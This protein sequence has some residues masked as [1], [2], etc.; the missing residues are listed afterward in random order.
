[1]SMLQG[2]HRACTRRTHKRI[3]ID[4]TS[5]T[6]QKVGPKQI[7]AE[8]AIKIVTSGADGAVVNRLLRLQ[9]GLNLPF[10]SVLTHYSRD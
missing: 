1:M 6:E 7:A 5:H 2:A 10:V 8:C 9:C 3:I 4:A